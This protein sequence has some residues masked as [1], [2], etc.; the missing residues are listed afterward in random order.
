[1]SL[2]VIRYDMCE[3]GR[4]ASETSG[5]VRVCELVS[6]WVSWFNTY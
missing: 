5:M 2:H 6:E 1:M 3:N 4:G